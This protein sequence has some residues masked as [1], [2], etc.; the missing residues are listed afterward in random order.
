MSLLCRIT[1]T[2][3]GG[4]FTLVPLA[5]I[6][7]DS[8]SWETIH[9]GGATRCATGTPFNF[10]VREADPKRVMIFFNGGGACWDAGSCDVTA[11]PTYRPFA[12]AEAG[13]DPRNFDGA[14][15]LDNAE[16]PF[17]EW[18]QIF[19]SYCTGDVHLGTQDREYTRVD[20][21]RFTVAHQ[22]WANSNAALEYLFKRFP[23]P[24]QVVVSGGSAGALSS[25]LFAAIIARHY[26]QARVIHFAGGAGGY[27]L[28]P[29]AALWRQWGVFEAFPDW[30]NAPEETPETLTMPD[31]YRLAAAAAPTVR[32]H[33]FDHAYDA[34]QEDFLRMLG[35]P[36]ELLPGLDANLAELKADLPALRSYV[37]PGEFHTLLRYRELYTREAGGVRA[38]D[39]VRSLINGGAVEDIHCAGPEGCR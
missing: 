6:A 23:E 26:T 39:W 16:N 28:P 5:A 35:H 38:V 9:P 1:R 12:T 29:P 18:S 30:Y 31:L 24:G 27:R 21:S 13:N 19:V 8:T 25:P 17:L 14:F 22:G 34:V 7:E 11:R 10:H 33:L 15:A 32:F 36:A 20:G 2:L 37:S 4:V 3:L